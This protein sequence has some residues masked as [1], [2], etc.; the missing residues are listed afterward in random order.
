MSMFV[1][2]LGPPG[3][4]KGTQA[5]RLA[6]ALEVPHISSGDLFREH[7][8]GESAL[9]REARV[10]INKGE[11]VPDDVTIGMVEERLMRPDCKGGAILDGFPRTPPQAQALDEI[12]ANLGEQLASRPLHA[13]L[14]RGVNRPPHGPLDV[15]PGHIYHLR[16]NPPKEAGICDLDGLPLRQRDDDQEETVKQRIHVYQVQTMP[17]VEYYTERGLLVEID[18]EQPIAD[19]TTA[20][21]RAVDESAEV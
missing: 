17:L 15:Q 20:L 6:S 3:A 12:L 18:G 8:Q 19:V 5:A 14:R 13:G 2:L 9:G 7:L 1:V 11:L 16:F 10:Y 4:G 21:M